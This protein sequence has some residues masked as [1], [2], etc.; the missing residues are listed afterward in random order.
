MFLGERLSLAR[1]PCAVRV[2]DLVD[3]WP[4]QRQLRANALTDKPADAV[5]E[6]IE[7][8]CVMGAVPDNCGLSPIFT[9]LRCFREGDQGEDSH[10]FQTFRCKK[11]QFAREA[12][13]EVT[14]SFVELV[15][16]PRAMD[17]L[18][19]SEI[20]AVSVSHKGVGTHKQRRIF[21]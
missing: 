7:F 11:A 2:D 10:E 13:V 4:L 12:V 16:K 21:L 18:V 1:K 5:D 20:D 14:D 3:G 19:H 9:W 6:P 8:L 17:T 15:D